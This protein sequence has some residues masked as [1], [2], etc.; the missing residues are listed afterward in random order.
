MEQEGV[1]LDYKEQATRRYYIDA[2]EFYRA[3]GVWQNN[4]KLTFPTHIAHCDTLE[5]AKLVRDALESFP[6]EVEDYL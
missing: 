6:K 2:C 5:Q 1:G 4:G 3:W